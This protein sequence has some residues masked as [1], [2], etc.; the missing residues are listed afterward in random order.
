MPDRSVL[1]TGAHGFLGR[2]VAR[3]FAARGFAVF[4][5]GHGD[6]REDEWRRWGLAAWR[7]SDVT[8]DSLPR[9]A[10]APEVVVHCAGGSSVA[11]S[12]ARPHDDF[13][14]TVA[15]TA[16]V[17]EFVR[18]R[19]PAARV[20]FPSS[21]SVYGSVDAAAAE[22][23]P[24]A[25]PS[26]YAAH[27]RMAEELCAEYGRR[28]GVASA[29]VRFFSLYGPGL[30][31][32]LLW[33]ACR[34]LTRGERTFD[35]TGQERRDFLHVDDAVELAILA[36]ERAAP[37]SPIVNGGTGTSPT[38]AEVVAEVAAALPG[39]GAPIFTGAR[40][41]GDPTGMVADTG[42]ARAWGWAPRVLWTEG[43]RAYCSWFLSEAR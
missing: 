20:L 4:G 41:A 12:V 21:G 24:A 36:A 37:A 19:S 29:V 5:I 11:A 15:T 25:P 28:F 16:S 33:D 38:I 42:R 34:R 39:A 8:L 17:L 27:K 7:A 32:Q 30:R 13:Q 2:R 6:W 26:P 14:R 22:D 10:E 18:T 9:A 31:K 43:V 23:R 35:G 3:A 1:V 40:R